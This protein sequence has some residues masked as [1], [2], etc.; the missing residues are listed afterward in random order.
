MFDG[1]G[2][3]LLFCSVV[4]YLTI[5]LRHPIAMVFETPAPTCIVRDDADV[6]EK[7]VTF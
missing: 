2:Y 7:F 4:V 5:E 3:Q 1:I 6:W